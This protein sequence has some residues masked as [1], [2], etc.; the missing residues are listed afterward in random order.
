MHALK[1]KTVHNVFKY[2]EILNSRSN[3]SVTYQT[4]KNLYYYH[5][6]LN[7]ISMNNA[8][9]ARIILNALILLHRVKIFVDTR[10]AYTSTHKKQEKFNTVHQFQR[11]CNLIYQIK[12]HKFSATEMKELLFFSQ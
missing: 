2:K 3:K 6:Y 11:E 7:E 12:V 5:K 8:Y 9:F 10:S 4:T 1:L